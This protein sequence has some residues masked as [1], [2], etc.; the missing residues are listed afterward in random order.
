MK[1]NFGNL[2]AVCITP[3]AGLHSSDPYCCVTAEIEHLKGKKEGKELIVEN[4][5]EGRV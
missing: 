1:S 3:R 5:A 4:T 2:M